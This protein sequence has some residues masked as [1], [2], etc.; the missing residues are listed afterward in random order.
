MIVRAQPA[1][2]G[3]SGASTD[4]TPAGFIRYGRFT[5]SG[6]GGFTTKRADEVDRGLGAALLQKDTFRLSAALRY[7]NG[8]QQDESADLDGMGDIEPTVRAQIVARWRPVRG[9]RLTGSL[10]VDALNRVGGYTV[11]TTLS[12]E[13]FTGPGQTWTV[14]GGLGAGSGRYLQAWYGVTPEQSALSGYPVFEPSAGL[15]DAHLSATWRTEFAHEWAGFVGYGY[16]RLLGPAADS[17]LTRNPAGHNVS[18]A[19][20][21]R[22]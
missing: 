11:D 9:W 10:G 16:S 4:V 14:S 15:R 2:S 21:W 8:R 18:T 19:L 12:R 1:Y 6:A 13:W 22:F 17:P 5:L 7:D 20:V 3:A